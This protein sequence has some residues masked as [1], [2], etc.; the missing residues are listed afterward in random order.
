M[1]SITFFLEKSIKKEED[2]IK[3]EE[4]KINIA[5]QTINKAKQKIINL[6]KN[7]EI[8][9]ILKQFKCKINESDLKIL[10][11]DDKVYEC[12]PGIICKGFTFLHKIVLLTKKYSRL[13]NF[14][15]EYLKICD[16]V[17]ETNEAKWSALHLASRHSRTKSSEKTVKIL[18]D[19]GL[20]INLRTQKDY[21]PLENAIVNSSGTSTDET[22]RI[23]INHI[24]NQKN[25]Q[26]YLDA[27]DKQ[28]YSY[29]HHAIDSCEKSSSLETIRILI[30]SGI[31]LNLKT[32]LGSN[33]AQIAAMS[34]KTCLIEEI[35]MMLIDAGIDLNSQNN[36]GNTVLHTTI[37]CF[38]NH[39]N[40][41]IIKLLLN[42]NIDIN[43]QNKNG[44]TAL[45][46]VI[47]SIEE[48]LLLEEILLLFLNCPNINVNLQNIQGKTPLHLLIEKKNY[49]IIKK[50]INICIGIDINIKDNDNKTAL[51]YLT[52]DIQNIIMLQ[53]I[54]ETECLICFDVTHTIQCKSKHNICDK[55]LF[56]TIKNDKIKCTF[57]LQD[58]N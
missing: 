18:L 49:F 52:K 21:T 47:S 13:N 38:K 50:F 39:Q 53:N 30:K 10:F 54:I 3:N 1:E 16:N 32:N 8:V 27:Q 33:A 28:N 45:H 17:N 35:F 42:S 36:N 48:P 14:L 2:D 22:V 34:L 20:D 29:L 19:A 40:E 43:L 57:C 55:C 5:N 4:N 6:K 7:I 37:I 24:M 46:A 25:P 15:I 11:D 58:Y 56:K 26:I 9:N 23:F 12:A 31:N 51:E 44:N 41:E